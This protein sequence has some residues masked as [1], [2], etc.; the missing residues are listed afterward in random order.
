MQPWNE[1][2]ANI[3][4]TS[5]YELN[6]NVEVLLPVVVANEEKNGDRNRQYDQVEWPNADTKVDELMRLV[7]AFKTN[8]LDFS[9]NQPDTIDEW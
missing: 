7:M 9:A 2:K 8:A 5:C 3:V 1:E 4:K 6:P